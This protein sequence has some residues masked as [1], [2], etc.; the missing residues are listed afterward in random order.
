MIRKTFPTYRKWCTVSKITHC[1]YNMNKVGHP[2][3]ILVEL[4]DKAFN[5]FFIFFLHC[6]K[7]FSER[8]RAKK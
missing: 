4:N 6:K 2:F 7:E 1:F 3:Q 8:W 5:P